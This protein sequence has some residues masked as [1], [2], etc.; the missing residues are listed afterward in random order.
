MSNKGKL[1]KT[2]VALSVFFT[3]L[4]CAHAAVPNV[5]LLSLEEVQNKWNAR[6]DNRYDRFGSIHRVMDQMN[7]ERMRRTNQVEHAKI[8]AYLLQEI[9]KTDYATFE[10]YD[11]RCI[12]EVYYLESYLGKMAFWRCMKETNNLMK[13]AHTLGRFKPL[14]DLDST[15][16][17]RLAW[18]VDGYLMSGK[19]RPTPSGNMTRR[20][21]G[22][23]T[24]Y[25]YEVANFRREYNKR[26]AQMKEKLLK[27]YRNRI[28]DERDIDHEDLERQAL[29][30]EFV[31][32]SGGFSKE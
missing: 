30:E 28:I 12:G 7:V 26:I 20:W 24:K 15:D 11:P 23:I 1:E 25:V 32:V 16:A 27:T 5:P 14:P 8:E 9:T 22:P 18:K 21:E 3:S 17:M 2:F 13:V 4:V 29:W 6:Y 31:R 19:D 10:D